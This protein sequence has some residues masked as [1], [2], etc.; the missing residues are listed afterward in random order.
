MQT[1]GP[2]ESYVP[3]I[4]ACTTCTYWVSGHALPV[5]YALI[6]SSI[7]PDTQW[8]MPR[9][10]VHMILLEVCT[11]MGAGAGSG[12]GAGA[13]TGQD[14]PVVGIPIKKSN[15]CLVG[16]SRSSS[17][18]RHVESKIIAVAVIT[19]DNLQ[20]SSEAEGKTKTT[21][22]AGA[23]LYPAAFEILEPGCE[24]QTCYNNP[25][26]NCS[27]MS[28]YL[29]VLS[30]YDWWKDG[31]RLNMLVQMENTQLLDMGFDWMP[32]QLE[33]QVLDMGFTPLSNIDRSSSV[34][35][36]L[37]LDMGFLPDPV[38]SSLTGLAVNHP[39][40]T[41]VNDI[42]LEDGPL[43]MGFIHIWPLDMGF[44]PDPIHNVLAQLLNSQLEEM[45]LDMGFATDPAQ[46]LAHSLYIQPEDRLL[47]MRFE[48]NPV[49]VDPDQSMDLQIDMG[50]EMLHPVHPVQLPWLGNHNPLDL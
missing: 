4:R 13:G 1:N 42:S 17:V 5:V 31:K 32:G 41:S 35:P 48:M 22:L 9:Y 12:I 2:E 33:S 46:D 30:A 25:W 16:S 10:P 26:M 37:A 18:G 50:F 8:C 38:D 21:C 27:S 29:D 43:D 20:L 47:D 23:Q 39:A 14:G 49:Q 40:I 7:C 44:G 28:A 36:I 6:P 11:G 24:E 34:A 45:S 15:K 19:Q 3:G